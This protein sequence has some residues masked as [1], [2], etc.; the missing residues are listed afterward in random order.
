MFRGYI[1]HNLERQKNYVIL[2][3]SIS[4]EKMKGYIEDMSVEKKHIF[5]KNVDNGN[6]KEHMIQFWL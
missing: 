4:P 2:L 6:L 3:K 1:D 5:K